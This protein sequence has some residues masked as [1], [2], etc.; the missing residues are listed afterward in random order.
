LS[1]LGFKEENITVLIDQEA[2]REKIL[3]E[4]ARLV[5]AAQSVPALFYFAGIGSVTLAHSPP[6]ALVSADG[7]QGQVLDIKL[8]EFSK[9]L[10]DARTNLV[11]I[12]DAGWMV[13]PGGARP[14]GDQEM[15]TGVIRAGW[16]QGRIKI[17]AVT[18][19]NPFGTE[20]SDL[21]K[22]RFVQGEMTRKL[23]KVLKGPDTPTLSFNRIKEAFPI[24]KAEPN[25]NW[26]VGDDLDAPIFTNWTLKDEV[27]NLVTT[28][29]QQPIRETIDL[30]RRLRD[31]RL[32]QGDP[33]PEGFLNLGIA[34]SAIGKYD[35]GIQALE[36]AVALYDN[37]DPPIGN[38]LAK[39]Q[40]AE[41]RR[42][43]AHYHLG[44][45]LYETGRNLTRAVSELRQATE[46]D[47]ENSRAYFYLGQAIRLLVERE[48][49]ADA[50]K[51]LEKY[52][53]YGAPLGHEDEVL[54]F[55]K[56]RPNLNKRPGGNPD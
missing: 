13:S 17:G 1:N 15:F 43:E 14:S 7:R 34:R 25:P 37:P 28:I 24:R 16:N 11:T 2:T 20:N 32:Q 31:Q 9:V 6:L 12:L 47:P 54:K 19:Y 39:D 27:M 50:E 5:E 38:E 51:A 41:D 21:D 26:L 42:T 29:E 35:K 36:R 3:E 53:A 55:L 48:T 49:L 44:R 22:W 23:L 33:Y 18:I 46:R 52:L 4:F 45:V 8:R 30:L 10:G 40:G 56:G